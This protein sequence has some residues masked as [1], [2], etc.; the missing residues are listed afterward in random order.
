MKA[1]LRESRLLSLAAGARSHNLSLTTYSCISV[2]TYSFRYCCITHE[3]QCRHSI[4]GPSQEEERRYRA[5]HPLPGGQAGHD[6]QVRRDRQDT[7]DS[8]RM[9]PRCSIWWRRTIFQWMRLFPIYLCGTDVIKYSARLVQIP[10]FN[11]IYFLYPYPLRCPRPLA[12][13]P[14][15]T[16]GD[17]PPIRLLYF[18]DS[19]IQ[20][21]CQKVLPRAICPWRNTNIQRDR[22]L[23][24]NFAYLPNCN[25][26]VFSV[27]TKRMYYTN[28][29]A[30]SKK[31]YSRWAT[32][33]AGGEAPTRLPRPPNLT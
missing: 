1:R 25:K 7:H 29:P 3:K 10:R 21:N 27:F 22:P 28:F 13:L 18:L 31:D 19:K 26:R 4:T 30:T 16:L 24:V 23:C 8:Q 17:R 20:K 33:R 32:R 9:T 15:P 5:L 12:A 11:Q 2:H 6:V 14:I